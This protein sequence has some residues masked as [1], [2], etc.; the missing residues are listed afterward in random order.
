MTENR[1]TYPVRVEARYDPA[2]SRWLWLVKPILVLPHALVLAALWLALVMTTVVAG[3]AILVAGRYPRRLFDFAVG[4]LRWTWRVS[5]YATSAFATDR[6]PPFR[7]RPDATYPAGLDVGY[8]ERL[9]RGL[10]L[11]KWWLLALPQYVV[12]G[13]LLGGFGPDHTGLI[14][15]LA[16]V[17]AVI[18]L[19]RKRYPQPLFD[20]IVGLNRWCLRVAGYALLLTDAYPP[21]RLDPGGAE[22]VPP[23]AEPVPMSPIGL[24]R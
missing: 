21:F 19:V 3:C 14:S 10:V 18:L 24:T 12:V 17:A 4:V 15:F 5:F 22:P 6:Y 23:Q 2:P 11:V 7:L 8:P 13:I 1:T 16:V 9:S 20:L